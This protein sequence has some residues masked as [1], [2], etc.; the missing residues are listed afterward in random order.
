LK[1]G[2]PARRPFFYCARKN[3][4]EDAIMDQPEQ[5]MTAARRLGFAP[6]ARVLIINA[7]D[8]GMC[9]DQNEAT[10]EGLTSGLF[11]S[12]TILVTCPWFE[13]AAEFGRSNPGADLGVHLTL[14]SEWERYK[15]GPVLGRT[16]V[17]S[18]VDARG[19][20]WRDVP[21]VYASDRLDE[22]EA[23]LRAQIDK[24]I[25]AGI[26]PTH[27]D[28]HMGPLHLRAD[29]HEIY[30]RLARDYRLPIRR[31]SR[32]VMHQLA[33]NSIVEE[34]ERDGILCPDNFVFEGPPS[35]A[36][37][38]AYWTNLIRSLKTGIT[39][40]LCH[41][42][43][44]RTELRGCA[45]DAQQREAD[46]RYFTS[47]KTRRLLADEGIQ[48]IGYRELRDAMRGGQSA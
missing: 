2:P 11:T 5:D 44:A 10:I 46:F 40:V 1:E 43:L 23:E 37:T 30:V 24:A 13:E 4:F 21:E 14:T 33:M 31:A 32:R 6:D 18:L 45:R 26:A 22:V 12:S 20:L 9:H 19:Y 3:T 16:A 39:E 17:P 36:D 38:E 25:H 35:P 29:Y 42:A 15:W 48:R 27:L 41:P 7:D 34:M 8:F 47:D 28:S